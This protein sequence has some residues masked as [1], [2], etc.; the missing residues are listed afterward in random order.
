MKLMIGNKDLSTRI[1]DH[2]GE[3]KVILFKYGP[4]SGGDRLLLEF[5]SN[6]PK[7]FNSVL[8]SSH[9]SKEDLLETF[10]DIGVENPPD[11][12]SL[13]TML[14]ASISDIE[15]KDRFL[16]DGIM[17]TDL[18][19][20]SSNLK[21]TRR[22]KHPEQ[23]MLSTLT[24]S[25]NRQ[26]LPFWFVLDSIS[27]IAGMTEMKELLMRLMILKRS[28]QRNGGIALLGIP[29][30]CD[31]FKEHET[32]FFDGV[33]EVRAERTGE[34]WTRKLCITNIKGKGTPP[35]EWTIDLAKDIPT[36]LSME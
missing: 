3:K 16:S 2:I 11:V 23:A 27:D 22:K 24:I 4:G 29:L 20:I 36:A 8:I 19:E 28:I 34:T 6:T 30:N 35:E 13:L 1:Q 33:V 14:D 31:I 21:E 5:F 12:I 10:K 25:A 32:T 7:S 17:V 26:V 9:E 18:L 15:K